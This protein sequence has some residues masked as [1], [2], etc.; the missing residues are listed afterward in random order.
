V[1]GQF[2]H[3]VA[4]GRGL[5]EDEV[6]KMA[7][8]RVYT[9]KQAKELKLVDELGGFDDAVASAWQLAGQSGEPRVQMPPKETALSLRELIHSA[10]QGAAS[11]AVD[12]SRGAARSGLQFLAPGLSE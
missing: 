4:E 7:E 9:G 1:Y 5:A 2:I 3:D 6:R 11:G 10:F 12:A 8:G